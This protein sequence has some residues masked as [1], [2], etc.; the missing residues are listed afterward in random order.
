M[1][2]GREPREIGG[3][4]PGGAPGVSAASVLHRLLRT[5]RNAL[6]RRYVLV[7]HRVTYLRDDVQVAPGSSIDR[8]VVIGRGT[9]I[10]GPSFLDPC[11]I[12]AYCAI[13]G[14]LVVRSGNHLMQYLNIEN[15][16][17]QRL[18][19]APTVLGP[20]EHV[21]I[22][23][24]VWIGDSVVVCPGVRIG[25]GAVVGAGAVVTRDVPD[26]AVVVG[27]PARFVRWRYPEH[28]IDRIRDLQWWLWD[29]AK[30]RRNRE[31][32]ELDLSDIEP[33]DLDRALA[34]IE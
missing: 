31:L 19:G 27:N 10:N 23:H 14:R 24:G 4:L 25:N 12:G 33:A 18:I 16:A 17:Q 9:R 29:A 11:E 26:F 13:G 1:D 34:R 20:R 22:G 5:L 30:L 15:D 6:R 2:P 8:N 7:R 3:L 28:V 21:R 32:F